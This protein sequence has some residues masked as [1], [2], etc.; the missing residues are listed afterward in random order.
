MKNWFLAAAVGIAL[1]GTPSLVWSSP[2]VGAVA[3]EFNL[4]GVNGK[5][6]RL[7]DYCGKVVVLEWFNKDC[8]YVRKHYDSKNMQKLQAMA[9]GKGHVWLTIISSAEGKEGFIDA[10]TGLEVMKNKEMSSTA[11]LLDSSG[12]VGK[13]YGAK[14][15]PHMFIV[16]Q[17]GKLAYQGAIDDRPSASAKSLNGAQ[18]YVAAALTATEKGVA[19]TPSQASTAP[20]GCGI[21]Y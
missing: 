2:E 1:V 17:K 21:K 3:P 16:D 19:L 8:P 12:Q 9:T 11:L 15:T 10:A 14:T 20:Y 6:Y 4:K 7:S 18:N 5:D 13:L